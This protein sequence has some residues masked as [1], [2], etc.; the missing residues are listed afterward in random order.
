METILKCIDCNKVFASENNLKNHIKVCKT[1]NRK[2]T[3]KYCKKTLSSKQNLKEHQFTH[4]KELPYVCKTPGC[5]L[6]F[7]QGSVLSSHKRIHNTIE[8][9][10]NRNSY[11]WIKLS[12]FIERINENKSLNLEGNGEKIKLPLIT[13]PQQFFI[14]RNIISIDFK[15]LS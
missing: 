15:S 7:R 9:Y 6:R 5:G 11:N 14:E 2:F 13:C 12:D 3:C 8:N 10:V 4:T 1:K